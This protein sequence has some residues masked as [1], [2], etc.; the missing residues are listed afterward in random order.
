M[1][2]ITFIVTHCVFVLSEQKSS[3]FIKLID[4]NG[5]F[6]LGC[7]NVYWDVY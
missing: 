6:Y 5:S 4:E 1:N 3:H 7:I 2:T